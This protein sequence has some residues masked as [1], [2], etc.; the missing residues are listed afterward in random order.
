MSRGTSAPC[1]INA[2]AN[3]I[4]GANQKL[5]REWTRSASPLL[6]RADK[7]GSCARGGGA[8]IASLRAA[9]PEMAI[10]GCPRLPR[11]GVAARAEVG[12]TAVG[13][14]WFRRRPRADARSG[15][16]R[17]R[18]G[19]PVSGGR[20]AKCSQ[21]PGRPAP[22][23]SHEHPDRM[24]WQAA[25]QAALGRAAWLCRCSRHRTALQQS[26]GSP[27][28]TSSVRKGAEYSMIPIPC[29]SIPLVHAFPWKDW[30]PEGQRWKERD[31]DAPAVGVGLAM[32][33]A[34]WA[35]VGCCVPHTT[36]GPSDGGQASGRWLLRMG[37]G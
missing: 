10:A 31:K 21:G 18:A 3:W 26:L 20:L 9:S 16:R 35:S 28:L 15:A 22:A 19:G 32:P 36:R 7:A 33:G 25:P 13:W 5:E 6:A 2:S 12:R 30:K 11:R 23:R 24:L 29:L 27:L 17:G 4:A 8:G 1:D 37:S 14:G 34:N